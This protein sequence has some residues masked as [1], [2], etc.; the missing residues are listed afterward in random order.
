MS[1]FIAWLRGLVS[2]AISSGASGVAL[3]VADPV[4]FNLQKGF[5]KLL[6]VCGVLAIVHVALYLQKSPLPNEPTQVT[7][8]SAEKVTV[9]QSAPTE[10]AS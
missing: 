9:N 8:I 7:A 4:T 1:A 3:V 10:G 5:A 2:V 6:E